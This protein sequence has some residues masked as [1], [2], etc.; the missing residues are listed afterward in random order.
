MF[1]LLLDAAADWLPAIA[2]ASAI[3]VAAFGFG[4][5]ALR[6]IE[7]PPDCPPAERRCFA[8]GLGLGILALLTFTL[9]L[10][11][12]L[13]PLALAGLLAMGAA[14]WSVTIAA[15]QRPGT[16]APQAADQ[17]AWRMV[18]IMSVVCTVGL[19]GFGLLMPEFFHD[20]LIYHLELP[21]Y[22]LRHHAI[23]FLPWNYNS[24][25]PANVE[26]LYLI[27]L[28]FADERAT[29]LIHAALGLLCVITLWRLGSLI[30]N[31]AQTGG[32]AGALFLTT[33]AT[34]L[35]ATVSGNDLGVTFFELL[36]LLAWLRWQSVMNR[37]WLIVSA[38]LMGLALGTKYSA[39]FFLTG[40]T[41]A[42]VMLVWRPPA[43]VDRVGMLRLAGVWLLIALVVASP[44]YLK[45]L[46]LTGDPFH[47][48]FAASLSQPL[49]DEAGARLLR[50]DLGTGGIAPSLWP[51]YF[52]RLVM[53]DLGWLTAAAATVG[54]A[55]TTR[56]PSI[57]PLLP[58]TL[59]SLLAWWIA[60]PVPRY[61][62][63]G[64]A[65]LALIAAAALLALASL[66]RALR[67]L[68]WTVITAAL[69]SQ[70]GMAAALLR[71]NY[72]APFTSQTGLTAVP[73]LD[74]PGP[75]PPWL[76]I[77][78][79]P[80][81]RRWLAWS[82]PPFAIID[83]A[84]RT[85]P[86]SATVLFVG[87]YRGYYLDRDRIIGSKYN[88]SPLIRWARSASTADE[89]LVRLRKEG[90]TH[91]IYNQLEARRL[92]QGGYPAVRWPDDRS[93][94]LFEQLRR[95]RFTLLKVENGVFLYAVGE[96]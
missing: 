83:E 49:M 34:A 48:I 44:W 50:R 18:P 55:L 27:A 67:I 32:L 71:D 30:D 79:G 57:R 73:G 61:L 1:R 42:W 53:Q 33:P 65:L 45:N 70:L 8:I 9:G 21:R 31:R 85:L 81:R 84:N 26:L 58:F 94:K 7:T 38:L 96:Q 40:F 12:G 41:I 11:G 60:S 78:D 23:T 39:A 77:R 62:V 64:V 59:G 76:L 19:I 14:A 37:R 24:A 52:P 20:A 43:P 68:T 74:Q 92:E 17:S 88:A 35:L 36:S 66:H 95:E 5:F 89:L 15:P 69:V 25:L 80:E 91:L 56:L 47:P 29:K 46:A 72:I 4:R 93:R 3:I 90:I 63:P 13:Y 87:E 86:P 16:S 54:M 10:A 22:Y 51:D 82:V 2:I 6:L 28:A 75:L